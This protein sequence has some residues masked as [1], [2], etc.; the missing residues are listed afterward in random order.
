[1]DIFISTQAPKSQKYNVNRF[2]G[3]ATMLIPDEKTWCTQFIS[4]DFFRLHDFTE[5]RNDAI[6][7]LTIGDSFNSADANYTTPW[8]VVLFINKSSP[9]SMGPGIKVCPCAIE[10]SADALCVI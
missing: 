3:N 9:Q 4:L 5:T 6:P 7:T 1:M 2:R 10:S 8:F